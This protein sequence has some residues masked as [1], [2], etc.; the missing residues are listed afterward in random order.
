MRRICFHSPMSLNVLPGIRCRNRVV[1][2]LYVVK[3][4]SIDKTNRRIDKSHEYRRI[5]MGPLLSDLQRKMQQKVDQ[6]DNDPLKLLVYSTHDTAI[7]GIA[8][9]LDVFDHRCVF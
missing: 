6:G 1:W 8:A 7:A 3:K 2:R 9:S 5:A 4:E